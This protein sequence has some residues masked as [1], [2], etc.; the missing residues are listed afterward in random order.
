M[1]LQYRCGTFVSRLVI[2]TTSVFET[3]SGKQTN[4]SENLTHRH[5]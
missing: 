4:S 2:L 5:G 3:L 1:G